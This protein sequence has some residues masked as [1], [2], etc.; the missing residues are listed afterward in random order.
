LV[1]P[2]LTGIGATPAARA[3]LASLLKRWAPAISP[4]SLAAV[5]GPKPGW[6]SSCGATWATRSAISNLERVDG[7]GQ[8]AQA[9]QLVASDPNAHRLLSAREAPGDLRRPFLRE[10]RA[11][12]E[13]ELGPE[14]VEV[15]LQRAVE[16][17]ARADQALAMV[18]QQADVE[19]R[20]RQRRRR[21]RL[22]PGRKGCAR[23]R[24]R[25]DLIALA[26]LAA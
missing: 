8:L 9:A 15:P 10:Q 25:I 23:D 14:V 16:R 2:G 17:D 22:D 5:R 4:M 20:A 18:N 1:L 24:D 19:L 7:D 26:A 21:Q 12:G 3:S 6:V 11:T 13:R